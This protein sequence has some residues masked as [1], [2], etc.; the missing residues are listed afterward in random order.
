MQIDEREEP[1][2]DKSAP[3]RRSERLNPRESEPEP[4]PME[5][6]EEDEGEEISIEDEAS[7]EALLKQ[8]R[9]Y[10]HR[11]VKERASRARRRC[12]RR[13]AAECS[14]AKLVA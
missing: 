3:R 10:C 8:Q 11:A 9:R 2:V 1:V 4:S 12:C 13:L 5:M 7:L 14:C 6:D